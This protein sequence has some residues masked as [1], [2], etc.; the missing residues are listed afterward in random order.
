MHSTRPHILEYLKRIS[1]VF[2]GIIINYTH[3]SP[4]TAHIPLALDSTM[5]VMV[6]VLIYDLSVFKQNFLWRGKKKEKKKKKSY[7]YFFALSYDATGMLK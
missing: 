4:C 6:E 7:I 3:A 1:A 5:M 2:L